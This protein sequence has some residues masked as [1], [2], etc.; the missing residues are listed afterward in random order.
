MGIEWLMNYL[1]D[2]EIINDDIVLKIDLTNKR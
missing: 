1:S 2:N